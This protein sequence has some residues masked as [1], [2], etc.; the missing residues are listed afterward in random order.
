MEALSF[1]ETEVTGKPGDGGVD[2]QGELDVSNLAKVKL[3]VQAK[4]YKIGHN[5]SVRDVRQFRSAIP[6]DGQG[7]F[8]TTSDYPVSAK[9]VALEPNFPRIGLINGRQLVDLLV[10]N[11]NSIPKDFQDRLGLKQG[12]VLQ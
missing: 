6:K 4:R 11:W 8:I 1:E 12:L 10:L 3:F 7:A 9:D 2:V 5:V